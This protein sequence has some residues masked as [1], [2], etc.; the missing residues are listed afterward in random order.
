MEKLFELCEEDFTV[1]D[2]KNKIPKTNVFD[3]NEHSI[4]KYLD[5]LVKAEH[6]ISQCVAKEES[7]KKI[8][9]YSKDTNKVP[10]EISGKGCP[11]RNNIVYKNICDKYCR[12][13][14]GDYSKIFR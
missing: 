3:Y 6:L 1:L 4:K 9:V 2:M 11:V 12:G 14:C 5:G 10:Y 13:K 8:T 7:V